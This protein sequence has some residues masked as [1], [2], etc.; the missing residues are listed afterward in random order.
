MST[1]SQQHW[2]KET[3]VV[4]FSL[5]FFKSYPES[6]RRKV[7]RRSKT[8]PKLPFACGQQCGSSESACLSPCEW[9]SMT[10]PAYL[11]TAIEGSVAPTGHRDPSGSW[12]GY[13]GAAGGCAASTKARSLSQPWEEMLRNQL[14]L[15]TGSSDSGNMHL[16]SDRISF[17]KRKCIQNPWT[18]LQ[19]WRVSYIAGRDKSFT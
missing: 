15:H 10:Q 6:M 8:L 3:S 7:L 4:W 14:S 13:H 17:Q 16:I 9:G 11:L 1:T 18:Q 5:K 12:L 2:K 19:N